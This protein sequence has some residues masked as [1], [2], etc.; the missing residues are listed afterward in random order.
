VIL[1]HEWD[2][3]RR[4]MWDYVGLVRT[5]DRLD[6]AIERLT[7]ASAWAEDLYRRT[8]PSADLA[9]L[10]NIA[11]VGLLLARSARHRGESRGLHFLT[12]NPHPDPVPRETWAIPGPGGF[13]LESRTLGGSA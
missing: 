1:D 13:R 11:L 5:R 4:L 9:E 8:R 2:G 10:R 12:D 7:E 3:V 6:R